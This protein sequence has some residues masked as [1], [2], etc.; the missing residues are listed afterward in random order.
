MNVNNENLAQKLSRGAKNSSLFPNLEIL[1]SY[2]DF[3]QAV[4]IDYMDETKFD[5]LIRLI[6]NYHTKTQTKDFYYIDNEYTLVDQFFSTCIHE[7]THWLDHTSTLWGQKHLILTYN[8]INAWTNHK[9]D[10]FWRIVKHNSARRRARLSTY[11]TENYKGIKIF[12][13][14]DPWQYEYSCGVEF[15]ADGKPQEERPIIFTR[16]SSS[17]NEPLI[18][19]PF[20]VASLTETNAKNAEFIVNAQSLALLSEECRVIESSLY[21]NRIKESLYNPQLAIYSVASHHLA[22]KLQIFDI[23]IAYKFASALSILCLNLP[24]KLFDSLKIP[25]DFSSF[26]ERTQAFKKLSDPGFAYFTITW[27]APKYQEGLSVESWLEEA[28]K[29]SGLPS[30]DEINKFVLLE[31]KELE[32]T[33]LNGKYVDKLKS[34]LAIGRSNYTKRG[35]YGKEVLSF[36]NLFTTDIELPLILL[37][38]ENI[39]PISRKNDPSQAQEMKTWINEALDFENAINTFLE[40]CRY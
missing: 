36:Q 10:D 28:V 17:S 35:I 3:S 14:K 8:A 31:M 6:E 1:G 26:F 2:C 25:E 20:S 27:N 24:S 32:E 12:S 37:G 16:F 23:H 11:Y 29:L 33:I 5:Q 15:G 34:L 22:N 4:V 30:L 21:S 19:I 7:L 9:E 38:D 40:A 13:S 39:I 18:R